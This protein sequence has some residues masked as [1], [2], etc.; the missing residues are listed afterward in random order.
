M[1]QRVAQGRGSLR[2]LPEIMEK[3]GMKRP[4]IVGHAS[5]TAV[6]MRKHPGLLACP[7]FSGFHS[8]PDLSDVQ[9]GAEMYRASACDGLISIGGG[10]CIDTAKALKAQTGEAMPHIAVPGTAGTGSE[11]TQTAVMYEDGR[12]LSLSQP[13][14]RPEGVILN[15]DLERDRGQPGARVSGDH[16]GAG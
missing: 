10:S 2:K 13:E 9:A 5:L 1:F 16:R 15:A 6:L 12:K 7:V 14:L 4:L 3:T 8:N 11:A